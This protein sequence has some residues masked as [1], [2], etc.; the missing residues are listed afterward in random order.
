[1]M[2]GNLKWCRWKSSVG[3][4]IPLWGYPQLLQNPSQSNNDIMVGKLRVDHIGPFVPKTMSV[5]CSTKAGKTQK[6]KWDMFR[7]IW[8][9]SIL[10]VKFRISRRFADLPADLPFRYGSLTT[11][12]TSFRSWIGSD[13]MS[14]FGVPGLEF[15]SSTGPDQFRSE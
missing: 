4:L 7:S 8:H 13:R 12:R 14:T 1:M 5:T 9:V 2:S 3:S 10:R 6:A 11:L 15:F